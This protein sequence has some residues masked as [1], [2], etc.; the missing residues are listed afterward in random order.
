MKNYKDTENKILGNLLRQ[1]LKSKSLHQ[2]ALDTKLSYVTVHKIIPHLIKRK[3]IKQEK[4]GNANLI[5]VDFEHARLEDLSSAILFER[6]ELI[7]KYP[8]I[9]LLARDIEE[10]L[11]SK[12]YIL[13]LFGSYAR[14]K[15]KKK[16]DMDI[17][18]IMP[19]RRDIELYKEKINK[20]LRL[21]PGVKRDFNKVDTKDFMDMLNQKYTVGRAVFE[22]GIV[23][24]GTEH[25]YSM[26][27]AYVRTKGY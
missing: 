2:I 10:A 23:L 27:K 9:A 14:E 5:S 8:Q 17:L 12:F 3:L 22:H 15:P 25:Y 11:T 4:K 1:P 18:F 16:S 24:F 6:T 26:V 7:K 19:Y 13:L 21:H 20:A